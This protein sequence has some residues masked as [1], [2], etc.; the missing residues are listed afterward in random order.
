MLL[1]IAAV[2]T[3]IA[4][5]FHFAYP[6]ALVI[7]GTIVGL[8][9]I[10]SLAELKSFVVEDEV[11]HF[12]IIT[13]FLPALLGEATLKLPMKQL[14]ENKKIILSLAIIGT[15]I[16][17]AVVGFLSMQFLSLPIIVA[18]TFAALMA[19]T[20]PVSVLSIFKKIGVNERLAAIL[21]GESLANDGVAVV[22][23]QVSSI[24]LL[25]YLTKGVTGIGLGVLD[26]IGVS[27]GG[28]A[29]GAIL[30]YIFSVLTRFY[31][32]YPVEILFSIVLFYSAFLTAEHFHVSGVIAVVVAGL[33]L[34]N[35][36]DR[37]MTPKAK[38]S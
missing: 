1:A 25:T 16:S 34:G 35:Y 10:Q 29:I 8:S 15:L 12:I 4:K 22:L 38:Y 28:I 20:D 36:G 6:I 2:V 11:F 9:P 24:S 37:Y 13:I 21:E 17:Y 32:D 19:A 14:I 31:D 23:F 33:V 30:G 27:I 18:F 5:K 26:F 7:I 3:A